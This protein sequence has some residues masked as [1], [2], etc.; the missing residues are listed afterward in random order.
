MANLKKVKELRE[1]TGVSIALCNKALKEAK[2][3]VA[4]ATK[5]LS[6]WGIELADK[7]GG[8]DTNSGT[9]ASY[10]H[11]NGRVAA[12]VSLLCETDFVAKNEKFKTL[13][14]EIAMQIA[15]MRPKTSKELLEQSYIRDSSITVGTLIKQNIALLGENIRIGEFVR[16]EL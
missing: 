4:K 16:L 8:R 2:D 5:L 10:V 6:K 1:S 15:S 9:I 11:H 3:D 13:A 7:K 12:T 14:Y